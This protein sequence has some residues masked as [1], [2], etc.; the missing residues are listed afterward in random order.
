VPGSEVIAGTMLD[1][2]TSAAIVDAAGWRILR[3]P[4][5]GRYKQLPTGDLQ[6]TDDA[7]YALDNYIANHRTELRILL[8]EMLRTW[9]QI[10]ATPSVVA[11][12]RERYELLPHLPEGGDAE[13]LAYYRESVAHDVFPNDGGNAMTVRDDL[14]LYTSGTSQNLDIADFWRFAPLQ[15]ARQSLAAE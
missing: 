3:Q 1:G 4:G 14:D 5:S 6:G 10:N 9:R 12:L 8:E 15:Q 13:V 2:T 7:L 11:R